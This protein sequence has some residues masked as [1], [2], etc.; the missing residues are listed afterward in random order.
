MGERI[1]IGSTGLGAQRVYVSQHLALPCSPT[2]LM[3]GQ[4]KKLSS[5]NH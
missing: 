5:A 1:R 4:P 3:K 2:A